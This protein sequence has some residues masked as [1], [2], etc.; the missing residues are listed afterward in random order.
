MNLPKIANTNIEEI[1][2]NVNDNQNLKSNNHNK[3]EIHDVKKVP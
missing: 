3:Y 1:E 2:V